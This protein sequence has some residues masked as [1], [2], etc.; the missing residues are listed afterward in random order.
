MVLSVRAK[1]SI[2]N[3]LFI[4]LYLNPLFSR[5]YFVILCYKFI[6][7][8]VQIKANAHIIAQII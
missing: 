8:L 6:E 2:L 1:I 5:Y 3:I 4:E 7:L